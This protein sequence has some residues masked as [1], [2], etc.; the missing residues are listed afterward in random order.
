ML[1]ENGPNCR[2]W[3]RDEYHRMTEAGIFGP[4]ERLELIAGQIIGPLPSLTPRHSTAIVLASQS[5]RN[6]FGLEYM[7]EA[8]LPVALGANSEPEPDISVVIGPPRR[9]LEAHP[10]VEDTVLVV[11][12]IDGAGSYKRD[13]KA[14]LYAKH[15]I[16]DYWIVNLVDRCVEVRREPDAEIGYRTIHIAK[17]DDVIEPLAAPGKGVRVADLLP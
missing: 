1:T 7:I 6:V 14:R 11:E 15:G 12:I 13:R 3:T 16:A 8:R 2:L 4:E 9:Y 17:A 5:L 10:G